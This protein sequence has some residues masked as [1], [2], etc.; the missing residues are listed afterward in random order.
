MIFC[1]NTSLA[2]SQASSLKLT[3]SCSDPHVRHKLGAA[4]QIFNP[5]SSGFQTRAATPICKCES[6]LDVFQFAKS[7]LVDRIGVLIYRG[8]KW[9]FLQEKF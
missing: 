1:T 6:E 2:T 3:F 7:K 5:Y 9:G 8:K 4:T